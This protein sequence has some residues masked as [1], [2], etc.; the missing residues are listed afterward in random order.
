MSA[1]ADKLQNL[2]TLAIDI[3]EYWLTKTKPEV[4]LEVTE[5][6]VIQV[7]TGRII[8]DVSVQEMALV[9]KLLAQNEIKAEVKQK[10]RTDSLR[11]W[12]GKKKSMPEI[13]HDE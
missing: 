4:V 10:D 9:L 2:Q 6:G 12:L 3:A 8:P 13:G 5:E 7:P 11:A 1:D